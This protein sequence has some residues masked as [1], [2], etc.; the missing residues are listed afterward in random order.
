MGRTKANSTPTAN[1]LLSSVPVTA[2]NRV[3][4]DSAL[5]VITFF[6]FASRNPKQSD[7]L[8]HFQISSL[9]PRGEPI[10][11]KVC[12]P[13]SDISSRLA[14]SSWRSMPTRNRPRRL[15]G[16]PR[17]CRSG[18]SDLNI[19]TGQRISGDQPVGSGDERKLG[20]KVLQETSWEVPLQ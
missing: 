1:K 14:Q 20:R 13:S 11:P 4:R 6:I 9:P 10:D 16:R 15:L 12:H 17:R 2:E 5:V 3:T 18:K 7:D 19:L 8:S